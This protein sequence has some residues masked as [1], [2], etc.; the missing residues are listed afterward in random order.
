MKFCRLVIL[1][2]LHSSKVLRAKNSIYSY[3]L[4][5]EVCSYF[6]KY[7]FTSTVWPT[8]EKLFL[9]FLH[10]LNASRICELT[11]NNFYRAIDPI[12]RSAESWGRSR[13]K[14]ERRSS[15]C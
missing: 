11:S 10:V 2:L 3:I 1:E 13:E 9:P 6:V 15:R 4:V 7:G 5:V 12:A 14:N 8:Q